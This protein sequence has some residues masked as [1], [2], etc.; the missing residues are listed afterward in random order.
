MG[1]EQMCGRY[2]I[3]ESDEMEQIIDRVLASPLVDKWH[4]T[5]AV[6]TYGEIRPTDVAAV[7]APNP[8]GE[9]AV[10]PMKWGFSGKTLLINARIE[11]ASQKPTFRNAWKNQRCIVPAS[12]YYEWEHLAGNDGKKATGDKYILQPN[13][14]TCTWLCGLYRIEDHMPVFVIL[15][16]DASSDIRFIHERMPLIMPEDLIDAWISPKSDPAEL[17]QQAVTDIFAQKAEKLS[18]MVFRINKE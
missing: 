7:I 4:K 11:T 2:Y 6:R 5:S 15:T 9:K 16:R 18:E 12:Y 3:E 10:F 8:K 14:K 17:V 13:G 1:E